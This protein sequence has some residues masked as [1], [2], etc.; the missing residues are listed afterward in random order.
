MCYKRTNS[1]TESNKLLKKIIKGLHKVNN[2]AINLG[3]DLIFPCPKPI[4][5]WAFI[6]VH[7]ERK[8]LFASLNSILPAINRGVIGYNDCTDGSEE[9]ILNFCKNKPG[10]IAVKSD[11][12]SKFPNESLAK[13]LT[14]HYNYTFSFIPKNEWFVK[15]D[16]DQ[17]YIADKLKKLFLLPKSYNDIIILPRIQLQSDGSNLFFDRNR[18]F[19]FGHDH[20]LMFNNNNLSFLPSETHDFEVLQGAENRR[21][22]I[23]EI[24]NWHFQGNKAKHYRNFSIPTI[25]FPEFMMTFDGNPYDTVFKKKYNSVYLDS[26][27]LDYEYIMK[28]TVYRF[29]KS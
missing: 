9:I 10:F 26:K 17:I 5:P 25:S 27:M 8:T 4:E 2:Y 23:G 12:F 28:S 7:N 21:V 1:K 13:K 3:Y 14:R 15:I 18:P 20:W 6:R 16:A 29:D 22:I 24:T 19:N 11:D